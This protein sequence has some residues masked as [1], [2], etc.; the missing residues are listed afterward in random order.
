MDRADLQ[1]VE[2][3]KIGQVSRSDQSPVSESKTPRRRPAG[4]SIYGSHRR[5]QRNRAANEIIQVA[6]F[7]DVQR[8]A[9]IGAEAQKGRSKLVDER[10][11]RC[12][13]FRDR[14]FADEYLHALGELLPT[15]GEICGLVTV[16]YPAGE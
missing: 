7:M 15:F 1:I 10:R 8:I 4:C 6:L 12:Q 9:V 14:P 11:Q 2:Q 3:Q 5:A 16:F 13:I